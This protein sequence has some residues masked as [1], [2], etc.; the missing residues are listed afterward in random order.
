MTGRETL[1]SYNS[2]QQAT[3]ENVHF[4]HL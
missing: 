4:N 3:N 1:P 2:V